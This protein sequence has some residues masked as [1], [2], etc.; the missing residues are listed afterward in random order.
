M[1]NL[2][3]MD[4]QDF[5]RSLGDNSVDLVLTDLPY[6]ISK[7]TNF[8]HGGGKQYDRIKISKD[9]G[10]WD[11]KT[12]VIDFESLLRDLYRVLRPSGTAILF[13][14]YWGITDLKRWMEGARFRMLRRI[15]WIKSNPV[16]INQKVTYLGNALEVAVVG[17]KGSKPTFHGKYDNGIYGNDVYRC[18]VRD[19]GHIHPTQKPLSL[20]EALVEKHSNLDDTVLD[21]FLG[22]GTTA[23]AA[24]KTNRHIVG[25]EKDKKYYRQA[26]QRVQ[27]YAD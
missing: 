4:C 7:K 26:L 16:P 1:H 5:V 24:L 18:P 13:Y 20:F 12:N 19:G 14:D 21:C 6:F 3:Q 9:F 27:E 10:S 17:V 22:S 15:E 8:K 25:C 2:L 11:K 23:I